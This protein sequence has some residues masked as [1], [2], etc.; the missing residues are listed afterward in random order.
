T[1]LDGGVPVRGTGDGPADAGSR[2]GLLLHA[3]PEGLD[4]ALIE[5]GRRDAGHLLGLTPAHRLQQPRIVDLTGDERRAQFWRERDHVI[6]LELVEVWLYF[7][8]VVWIGYNDTIIF[9]L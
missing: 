9:I 3:R 6:D 2:Q 4:H 1:A 5:R 7:V 8:P